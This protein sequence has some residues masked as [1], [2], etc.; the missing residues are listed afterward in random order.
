MLLKNLLSSNSKHGSEYLNRAVKSIGQDIL[1]TSTRGTFK[2][3]KHTQ[4]GMFLKR[5]S[6]SKELITCLNRLGH[7]IS[8]CEVLR[9]ETF[10]AE[11]ESKNC[12]SPAYIPREIQPEKFVTY[13]YDNCDHNL[14]SLNGLTMHCTN[15]IMIQRN[16][17]SHVPEVI[18]EAPTATSNQ[19]TRR[20]F[21]PINMA[22]APYYAPRDRPNPQLLSDVIMENNLI[23]DMIST[24]ADLIWMFARYQ[25]LQLWNVQKV[26][27]W[28]GFHFETVNKN[29]LEPHSVHFLPAINQ[30]PTRFDTVQEV[31]NQVQRKA[32][33]LGHQSCL[34]YTSPS[35]RDA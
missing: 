13:V 29:T 19:N 5:K 12:E 7:C 3:V 1:Y 14:E 9:L 27:G 26:P 23:C 32:E 24:T 16:V 17:N 31:L 25:S 20:S 35:P 34:L 8:Y 6:G 30:S 18:Q 4:L 22:V 2:T 10:I 15:G 21:K 11:T 33:I 28:T